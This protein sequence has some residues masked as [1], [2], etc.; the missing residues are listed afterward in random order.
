MLVEIT[1]KLGTLTT[2]EERLA[3]AEAAR[4]QTPLWNNHRDNTDN[5]P[6]L[7][8]QLPKSINIDVPTFDGRHYP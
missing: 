8:D 4:D 1:V 5:L 3:K 7:Y 2:I 6:I